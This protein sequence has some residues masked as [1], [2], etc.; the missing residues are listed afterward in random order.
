MIELGKKVLAKLFSLDH[1]IDT[2]TGDISLNVLKFISRHQDEELE[3]ED[4]GDS[5][6]CVVDGNAEI[7]LEKTYFV[8]INPI[9]ELREPWKPGYN[10]CYWYVN[11]FC[12]IFADRW[13]NKTTDAMLFSGY[14]MF[15][16]KKQ[17]E[18]VAEKLK[19][20][21]AELFWSANFDNGYQFTAGKTN[22]MIGK[23]VK[24]EYRIANDSFNIQDTVVYYSSDEKASQALKFLG[25]EGLL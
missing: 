13:L 4:C 6:A 2:S 9:G 16:I 14:N 5:L 10:G 15:A 18:M 20:Y 8:S 22:W 23:N 12:R 25:E 19:R 1:V 3:Y 17:A 21:K 11:E 7:Q 24:G